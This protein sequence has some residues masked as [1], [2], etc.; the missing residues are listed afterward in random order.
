VTNGEYLKFI[1]AGAYKDA[2]Y[3]HSDAWTWLRDTKREY[4]LYWHFIDGA[5]HRYSLSGL[6]LL[7]VEEPITHISYYEAA[8]YAEWCGMRLPTEFEWEAACDHFQWGQRWEHTSSAYLPYPGYTKPEGALGEYNAKFMVNQMVLRG[9]SVA[10]PPGHA[11]KTYRN[12]FHAPAQW[13]FNGIRL[14]EK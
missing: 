9:A 10:T 6:Q 3:W 14:C 7:P 1:E 8:A 12:F 13:Q 2:E 5:W 4:P 11:R